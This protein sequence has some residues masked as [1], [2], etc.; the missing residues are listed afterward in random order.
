MTGRLAQQEAIAT[1]DESYHDLIIS[2][3]NQCCLIADTMIAFFPATTP[4]TFFIH[5]FPSPP[6]NLQ[7]S[8]PVLQRK[9]LEPWLS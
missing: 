5:S 8:L 2:L 9:E 6:M 7:T 4:L 1:E 3:V